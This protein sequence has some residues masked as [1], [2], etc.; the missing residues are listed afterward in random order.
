MANSAASSE[1]KKIYDVPNAK[2]EVWKHFGFRKKGESLDKTV[3]ICKTC[4][5]EMKYTGNTTNMANHIKRR[6][7]TDLVRSNRNANVTAGSESSCLPSIFQQ[8]LPMN[9]KR[10]KEVTA[11]IANFICK[12]LRPYCV[13]ENDGFRELMHVVEPRY[14][15]PSR[16]YF[17]QTCIPALYSEVKAHVQ[18]S[19]QSADRIALTTDGWTSCSTQAYV[20][21]TSHHIAPDWTMQNYVLQTRI[22]NDAHT[23]KNIGRVL[24]DACSEW[25]ITEK[26]PALVSDNAR[27]MTVAGVEAGLSP[28]VKCFAHT[29]NLATQKSLKTNGADRL[30]GKVRRIVSFFHRSTTATAVLKEKQTLLA[31]PRH[32]L[33][34][35]VVTRWNSSFD[36]LERFIEQQTA[37]YATLLDKQV[38]GADLSTLND[39][40]FASAEQIVKLLGPVKTATTIMCEEKQPTVSIIAPLHAKLLA[41]CEVC[42]GEDSP[43]ITEMKSTLSKDLKDRYSDIQNVL[44][45]ASA[46][47]P[48]FKTLPFLNEEQ[49][50]L[51]YESIA[52]EA[53][54]LWDGKV[55]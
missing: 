12:D 42:E 9:S 38:R 41:H 3:A 20:T 16:Q 50:D 46:L 32:K 10:A 37:V 1:S 49:K 53:A 33:I 17:S 47:D 48:R 52:S 22:L 13:V 45:V 25:D 23:G 31:I 18:L 34:Q 15:I 27:N 14:V 54:T 11:A 6:H 5:T 24:S 4:E 40:D 21:I 2:S 44:Y 55:S 29:I 26:T 8:K 28:H 36:M 51:T 43:L 39:R 19:L 30:L 35:D 7:S